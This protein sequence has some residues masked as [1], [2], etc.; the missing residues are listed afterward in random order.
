MSQWPMAIEHLK[1]GDTVAI[2]QAAETLVAGFSVMTPHSWPDLE[3]GL[4]EVREALEDGK[5]CLVDKDALDVVQGWIGGKHSYA[6]V[7]E[8]HPLVV[9]PSAQKRGIGR[10]LVTALEGEVRRRGGTAGTPA[11]SVTGWPRCRASGHE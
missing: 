5:I 8:L 2:R 7:W 11:R 4:A 6:R 10:S 9:H 1:P 3:S